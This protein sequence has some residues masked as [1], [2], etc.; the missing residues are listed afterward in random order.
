MRIVLVGC[1]GLA[2]VF[3]PPRSSVAQAPPKKE[4]Q[5]P[6]AAPKDKDDQDDADEPKAKAPAEKGKAGRD[7]DAQDDSDSTS[8]ALPYDVFREEN[9]DKL[10]EVNGFAQIKKPKVTQGDIQEFKG[11]AGPGGQP[12]TN[13]MNRVVDA[14]V[15]ELTDHA[16][17]QAFVDPS[18]KTNPQ[19]EVNKAINEATTTLLEPIFL[20]RTNKNQAFLSMYNRTLRS[21]LTPLLKNHLIPRVQA[22]IVL[23]QAA[24][25]DFFPI[26]VEQ[27]KDPKQ[28][29]WVKL[30]AFEGIV[31]ALEEG[32]RPG[33]DVLAK[34]AKDVAD[35]LTDANDAPYP[36]QLRALEALSAL[37][38]G[39]EPSHPDR[40]A[41]ASAA[42]KFLA[43]SDAKLELRSEAARALGLMPIPAS[44]RKYNFPLVAHSVGVL[45]ADLGAQ[46]NGLIPAR[47]EKSS[48]AKAATAPDTAKP[49]PAAK[50]PPAAKPEGKLEGKP[51]AK[52]LKK[53]KAELGTAP[54]PKE[55]VVRPPSTNP[56]KARY[57]TALLIGPVYQAFEGAPGTR[58]D[59]GGLVR[60]A[61]ADGAAY[62]QKVFDLV[63]P[64][65]KASIDL[66]TSGSRQINDR[67][68]DLQAKVDAL[69]DFLEK[70]PPPD[71]H[72]VQGG[73]DFPPAQALGQ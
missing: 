2:L 3:L 52:G 1:V 71:R 59:A 67:K 36:V 17:I 11:M 5:S 49:K 63:K 38:Q 66:I 27:I 16:N 24:S 32:G 33:G 10:L 73:A 15:A 13:L 48:A 40:A 4:A 50:A 46:I 69:R 57:L 34:T 23:G 29:V 68:K 51:A 65:A 30:W 14:M 61:N 37:R 21:K 18:P 19:A 22:M 60:N 47:P 62:S 25:G 42:M 7:N 56:N 20:A 12:E 26:Y 58:G 44:V 6:A 8:K 41:M 28:T 72:L 35:F 54:A 43:D 70:N 53:A 39:Y 45:A 55:A 64:V 31:N 9:I